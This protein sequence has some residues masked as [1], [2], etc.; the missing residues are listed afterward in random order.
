MSTIFIRTIILYLAVN[1]ALRIMGKRQIG[2]LEPA[3]FVIAIL[4]SE[5]ASVPMQD[6]SIP[7]IN[8]LI[9][10]L[11]LLSL[12]VLLSFFTLKS[13]RIREFL[14]GRPSVIINEGVLDQKE[15]EK[16]R[17]NL[18]DLV[19]E[20]RLKNIMTISDVKYAIMETNGKISVFPFETKNPATPEDLNLTVS[21]KTLPYIII[22]GGKINRKNLKILCKDENWVNQELM[23]QNIFSVKDVLYMSCD[24]D[25]KMSIIKKEEGGKQ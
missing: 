11:T 9:P 14:Q 19:K 24:K 20:M 13:S 22:S 2:E 18:D 10:I 15:I 16:L 5:L 4:I 3:E 21:E 7:I 8:G 25:N 12:E 17:F 23:K 1:A 6:N